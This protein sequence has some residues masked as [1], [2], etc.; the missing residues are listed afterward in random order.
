MSHYHIDQY[1]PKMKRV[2]DNVNEVIVGKQ[3]V[4]ELTLIAIISKGHVLLEDVPGVG[5]TVL[6][7][8]LAKSLGC[9]FKRIQ[10]TPDLLPSDVTGV[11]IYNQKEMLFEF[12]KGPIF[13]NIV[14][15]DEINRTSPKTQSALL[16]AMEESNITVD[17]ET[18]Q[19][20]QPFLVMATQNPIEYEG[21]FPLPEAQLDRFLLKMNM[22]YPTQDEE[23]Q[24][25]SRVQEGHPVDRV[26]PV[27]TKEELIEAQQEAR[28][29]YVDESIKDYIVQITQKTREHQ[30]VYLGASPRGSLALL[31]AAQ[32][33]AYIRGR[34]YVIPD[35]VKFLS[36]YT[37]EHRVIL[38]SEARLNGATVKRVLQE[39][40][41]SVTVPV[42][43]EPVKG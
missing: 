38:K 37:L 31:K 34:T 27:L 26:E 29:V 1:H 16:E 28:N 22:G 35:D 24:V 10:F 7:R 43:R 30:D 11:S 40:L 2:M 39:V 17:G 33:L 5:K 19:L 4:V 18:K 41:K 21:T 3:D 25:L 8:S 9:S 15:A 42:M 20:P 14:L 12:R 13:G 23:V 36:P 32:S 6:V